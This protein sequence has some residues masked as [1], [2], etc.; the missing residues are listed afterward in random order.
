MMC[1]H[2]VSISWHA[3]NVLTE[4]AERFET[5]GR[6]GGRSSSTQIFQ[7]ALCVA[8]WHKQTS[9]QSSQSLVCPWSVFQAVL[10]RRASQVVLESSEGRKCSKDVTYVTGIVK[11]ILKSVLR[12]LPLPK[13]WFGGA[14][15]P[16][17][18]LLRRLLF[19]VS[20]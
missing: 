19:F 20:H 14:T 16:L 13:F 11:Y 8:R 12:H 1:H 2:Q 17:F 15:G 6:A 9:L 5:W 10:L 18:P 4:A 3:L 7:S